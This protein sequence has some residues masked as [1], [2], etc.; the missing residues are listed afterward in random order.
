M[1]SSNSNTN[2]N[3][4]IIKELVQELDSY[5]TYTSSKIYFDVHC[6]LRDAFMKYRNIGMSSDEFELSAIRD[7][8]TP[9]IVASYLKYSKIKRMKDSFD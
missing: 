4:D 3:N 8:Y 2:T 1:S 9:K 6:V 5:A 7:D